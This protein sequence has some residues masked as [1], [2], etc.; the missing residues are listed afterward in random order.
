VQAK[1]VDR[2]NCDTRKVALY[3]RMAFEDLNE[4]V[5]AKRGR[6]AAVAR[7]LGLEADKVN[8][9]VR[10]TR[11]WSARE[12]DAIRAM[13][14]AELEQSAEPVRFIPLLGNVPAGSFREAVK[15]ARGHIPVPAGSVAANAY[16]LYPE[17]DSMDLVITP[18]SMIILDPDDRDLYPGRLYVIQNQSGETTFK[19]YEADPARL[20]PCSSNPA[21]KDIV[22]GRE[23]FDVLAR[24]VGGFT[25]F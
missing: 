9:S 24:V 13:M 2:R 25:N 21:H 8:K 6:Q 12:V 5:A 11:E 10:G 22:I 16:A 18:G 7:A 3:D 14:R 20:V 19:K 15:N 4:W 17:G 1:Y 23:P